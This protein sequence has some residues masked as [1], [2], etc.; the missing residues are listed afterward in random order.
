MKEFFLPSVSLTR[1]LIFLDQFV[2]RLA[3][4]RAFF[5][6]KIYL[7]AIEFESA[8]GGIGI[9]GSELLNVSAIA[10]K[11]LVTYDNPVEGLLF[12]P[13]PTQANGY[14]HIGSSSFP[15]IGKG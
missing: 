5:D 15:F 2:H 8:T 9:I 4:L 1:L 7:V 14:T 10:R 12:D 6:P 11:P 3:G 13:M